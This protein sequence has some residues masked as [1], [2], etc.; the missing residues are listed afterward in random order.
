MIGG[1]EARLPQS[2]PT[3]PR[4]SIPKRIQDTGHEKLRGTPAEYFLQLVSASDSLSVVLGTVP[5]RKHWKTSPFV[6]I[7]TMTNIY[8]Y[9]YICYPPPPQV[10]RFGLGSDV[11]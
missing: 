7:R 10:P 5:A 6:I 8:I 4:G 11:L 1:L 3:K 9:I 2:V